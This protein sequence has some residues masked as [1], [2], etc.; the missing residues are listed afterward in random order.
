MTTETYGDPADEPRRAKPSVPLVVF[1]AGGR[2]MWKRIGEAGYQYEPELEAR[3][4]AAQRPRR[5]VQL[6]FFDKA[7]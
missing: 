3:W 4:R 6:S 2:P 1:D 5:V 7:A